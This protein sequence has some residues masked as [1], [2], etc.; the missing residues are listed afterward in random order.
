MCFD[1]L[2]FDL[3]LDEHFKP[4]VLEVNHAPS[5]NLE[6]SLDKKVKPDMVRSIFDILDFN[7]K[8]RK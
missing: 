1:L 2:G 5:F 3:I 6:T 7:L 8:K 4:Y